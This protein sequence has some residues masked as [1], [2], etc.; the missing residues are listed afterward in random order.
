[1]TRKPI[2]D[3]HPDIPARPGVVGGRDESGSSQLE[4]VTSIAS[5]S[6]RGGSARRPQSRKPP[7][8]GGWNG[9]R[10]APARDS[11]RATGTVIRP[12]GAPA[13]RRQVRR[14]R[15]SG[16]SPAARA[17]AHRAAQAHPR[18]PFTQRR[19]STQEPSLSEIAPRARAPDA[20][21]IIRRCARTE[22]DSIAPRDRGRDRARARGSRTGGC[23]RGP[24]FSSIMRK[25]MGR[26]ARRDRRAAPRASTARC[27]LPSAR[28]GRRDS[29]RDAHQ[30]ASRDDEYSAQVAAIWRQLRPSFAL[31][32][33]SPPVVP[34]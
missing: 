31:I 15:A 23:R 24:P 16:R 3:L 18:R 20:V 17:K 13:A 5:V 12:R 32:H 33:S 7:V 14:G 22:L 6:S 21:S 25:R 11:K 29:D 1:M 19:S 10:P 8:T 28:V 30:A 34:K 2:V 4:V 26:N 9:T 27:T